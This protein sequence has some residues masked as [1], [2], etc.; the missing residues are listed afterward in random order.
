MFGSN[1][2][3][4]SENENHKIISSAAKLTYIYGNTCGSSAYVASTGISHFIHNHHKC[5]FVKDQNYIQLDAYKGAQNSMCTFYPIALSLSQIV[6][7]NSLLTTG[8]LDYMRCRKKK[9]PQNL[10]E[11]RFYHT[12][13]HDTKSTFTLVP[14]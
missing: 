3:C 9:I 7:H 14:A 13:T 8:K 1:D 6:K 12:S 4:A 5:R 10:R 11:N 2:F